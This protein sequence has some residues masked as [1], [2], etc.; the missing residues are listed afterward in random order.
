[1]GRGTST[2]GEWKADS[3][4][5]TTRNSLRACQVDTRVGERTGLPLADRSQVEVVW[6]PFEEMAGPHS[7]R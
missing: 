7:G 2:I 5:E 1:M 3:H 6:L 4:L